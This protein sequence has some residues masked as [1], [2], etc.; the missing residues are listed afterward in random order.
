M[1]MMLARDSI[2]LLRQTSSACVF[3]CL[4]FTIVNGV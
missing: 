3:G 4:V 1:M 2:D